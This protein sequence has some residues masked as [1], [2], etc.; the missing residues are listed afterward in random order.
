[1]VVVSEER[2]EV[3]LAEDRRLFEIKEKAELAQRFREHV[4]I[5][6]EVGKQAVDDMLKAVADI[7]KELGIR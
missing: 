5:E 4:G 2:G 1:M 7:E 3:V 6:K